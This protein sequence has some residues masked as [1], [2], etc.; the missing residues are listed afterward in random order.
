LTPPRNAQKRDKKKCG[1]FRPS[2]RRNT[3][4]RVFELPLMGGCFLYGFCTCTWALIFPAP[5]SST[6]TRGRW[7]TRAHIARH[8]AVPSSRRPSGCRQ[9]L[10]QSLG[11]YSLLPTRY[12]LTHGGPPQSQICLGPRPGGWRYGE[13]ASGG[14]LDVGTLSARM[15]ELRSCAL[16]I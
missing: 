8:P 1:K 7:S 9:M 16:D 4:K 12:S 6:P 10:F 5:S 2:F 13:E 11:R 15:A 14:L 3:S